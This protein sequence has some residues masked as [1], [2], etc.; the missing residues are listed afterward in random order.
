MA[1]TY[2]QI[3]LHFV[4]A[5][6]NR[7]SLIGP[8]WKDELYKYITGIIQKN[9]HKLIAINGTSNHL[10][11]LVGYK[12]HQP[13]PNLMQDVKGFS[14]KWINQKKLVHG[15]FN[16]QEGYGAFSY[17]SSHI[18]RVYKYIMNQEQ[19]HKIRTFRKEYL[20]LLK[21]YKNVYDNRYILKDI[22]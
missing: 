22:S 9:S 17:S 3:F 20:E 8:D 4:F 19:H 2:T 11:I 5:V 7:A 15:K 21:R 16:W 12:P 1:G 14:S 18:N 10:H 13:I 6:Q